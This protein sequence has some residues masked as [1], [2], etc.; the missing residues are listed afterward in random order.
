[1][2][3]NELYEKYVNCANERFLLEDKI[4][5]YIENWKKGKV[6]L[7]TDQVEKVIEK[8]NERLE[9]L[10]KIEDSLHQDFIQMSNLEDQKKS[11]DIAVRNVFNQAPT[12]MN[13][14]DGVLAPNAADSHL[15]VEKKSDEQMNQEK[16]SMLQDLKEKVRN[17]EVTLEQASKL[18]ADI[19]T[20][21]NFY[22]KEKELQERH[23]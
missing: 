4:N 16:I 11:A 22:N 14:V 5:D 1:M 17:G 15:V 10:K 19:N 20:S 18:S 9:D 8:A 23:L 2:F 6:V 3:S 7:N 12:N 21:F 13:V